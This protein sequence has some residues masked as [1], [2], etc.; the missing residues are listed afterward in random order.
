MTQTNLELAARSTGAAVT[1]TPR[2]KRARSQTAQT[3]YERVRSVMATGRWHA[4]FS[5]RHHILMRHEKLDS[6]AAISARLR[7][8]RSRG[9]NVE[10]RR[11]GG[12]GNL[13][14]YRINGRTE[15]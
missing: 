4:L 13:W 6:E 8:L 2:A 1:S 14:E 12:K 5:I 15:Q 7:E 10:K 9:W 11:R 3:Q